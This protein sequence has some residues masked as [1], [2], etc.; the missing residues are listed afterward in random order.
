MA[1]IEELLHAKQDRIDELHRLRPNETALIII[2]MQHGFLDPGAALEV[3]Q[4]RAIV[5]NLQRLIR[6]CRD[7]GVPVIFTEFAYSTAVPCLRGDPFGP[8]HLPVVEGQ[9][10]GF[11]YPSDNCVVAPYSAKGANSADTI[12]ELAPRSDE[13]VVRGHT[14][15]K[16]LGTP[17]DLSL[18]SRGI[19]YLVLTGIV[20][21]IC[22]NATL[23]TAANLNYRVTAVTDGMA[24][25][26]PDIQ[27]ACFDIWRRKF[28]R[29]RTAEEVVQEILSF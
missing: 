7:R 16:F 18:R 11:G 26:W 24:T 23:M 13:L 15:D 19:R 1:G 8:E 9:P 10:T 25:L 14:Y 22:V 20:T 28:A 3:P 27:R 4:G 2:D 5:P 12:A 17:L 6:S 29:L 21:D